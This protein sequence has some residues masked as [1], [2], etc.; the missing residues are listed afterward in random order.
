MYKISYKQ[1]ITN[2]QASVVVLQSQVKKKN[3]TTIITTKHNK[4]QIGSVMQS[5]LRV[6]QDTHNSSAR[7]PA[8]QLERYSQAATA[9][10]PHLATFLPKPSPLC[11]TG[12]P[13]HPP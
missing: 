11:S 10:S 8:D 4:T 3:T 5:T 12:L 13:P 7:F 6:D 9:I 1:E 2:S